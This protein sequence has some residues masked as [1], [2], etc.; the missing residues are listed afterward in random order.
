MNATSYNRLRLSPFYHIV[1]SCTAVQQANL[2]IPQE[3]NIDF[4]L[5]TKTT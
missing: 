4:N 2:Q 5:E 3:E 1:D